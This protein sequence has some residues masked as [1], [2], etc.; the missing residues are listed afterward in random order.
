MG[1][2]A[3]A[4]GQRARQINEN[5]ITYLGNLSIYN[6]KWFRCCGIDDGKVET[7]GNWEG[8]E[9]QTPHPLQNQPPKGAAPGASQRV[10][11]SPPASQRPG[12]RNRHHPLPTL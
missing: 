8:R 4:G 2:A 6:Y 7:R 3:T 10:K 12:N 11:G 5:I 9:S 1:R